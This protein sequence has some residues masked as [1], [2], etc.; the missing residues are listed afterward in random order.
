MN[1]TLNTDGTATGGAQNLPLERQESL[2]GRLMVSLTPTSTVAVMGLASM[3]YD[4]PLG[5]NQQ[6]QQQYL[7]ALSS[8][9][10]TNSNS[11]AASA[12]GLRRGMFLDNNGSFGQIPAQI[13]PAAIA[14]TLTVA[15][16]TAAAVQRPT[17]MANPISRYLSS[18]DMYGGS[19]GQQNVQLSLQMGGQNVSDSMVQSIRQVPA[20]WTFGSPIATTATTPAIFVG[21]DANASMGLGKI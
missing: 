10:S 8:H 5:L 21:S 16:T 13:N 19:S 1:N 9:A 20:Y 12:I 3:R 18:L 4:Q 11:P 15:S 6:Q 7:T 2:D 17:I 14:R